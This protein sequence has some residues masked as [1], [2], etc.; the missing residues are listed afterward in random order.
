MSRFHNDDVG[1]LCKTDPTIVLDGRRRFMRNKGKADK[2]MGI[3]RS[4][5]SEMRLLGKLLIAFASA[6]QESRKRVSSE[7]SRCA[8]SLR[9]SQG[10]ASASQCVA[11]AS[12]ASLED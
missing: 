4:T 8:G 12:Q 9:P 5:M 6:S 1:H 3:K 11:S 10:V 2:S 7:S